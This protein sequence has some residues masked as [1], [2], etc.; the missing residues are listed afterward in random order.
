[1]FIQSSLN[2][3][4]NRHNYLIM[5]LRKISQFSLIFGIILAATRR[6]A[7]YMEVKVRKVACKF[8]DMSLIYPNYTCFAKVYSRNVSTATVY[9][10]LRKPRFSFYVRNYCAGREFSQ[11]FF[12]IQGI[13]SYR[14][15]TIFREVIRGPKIEFCQAVKFANESKL[16]REFFK[17]TESSVP[18]MI[19]ECPYYV[20]IN[21]PD[22]FSI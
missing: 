6:P 12:Q 15:G 4:C 20:R 5:L 19:H 16:V 18:G 22:I 14:Y 8:S 9:Y 7:N 3:Q 11:L 21:Q 10:V 2:F 13:L 17:L 1:M